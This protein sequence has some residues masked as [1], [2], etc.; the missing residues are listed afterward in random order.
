MNYTLKVFNT[1]QI[2]LPKKW[3]EKFS[4]KNFIARETKEGL[5]I[6]PIQDDWVAYYE[7]KNGFGIYSEWGID[8]EALIKKIK[9]LQNG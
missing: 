2:T 9:R 5:L 7:D 1:G 8:P 3:R 6:Q 4:T